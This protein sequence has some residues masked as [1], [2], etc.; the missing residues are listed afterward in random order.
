MCKNLVGNKYLLNICEIKAWYVLQVEWGS[1]KQFSL[2][3]TLE[4][5]HSKAVI[6]F[7]FFPLYQQFL[8]AHLKLWALPFLHGGSQLQGWFMPHLN[9]SN[10]LLRNIFP[11]EWQS[12]RWRVSH[13]GHCWPS[14]QLP[15][16]F[17]SRWLLTIRCFRHS[18]KILTN[19]KNRRS[20]QESAH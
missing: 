17:F 10:S 12:P 2:E 14:S 15:W 20:G 18:V 5:N 13:L 8:R 7:F 11:P 1:Q 3:L 6:F 16:W 19:S 4:P 9:L